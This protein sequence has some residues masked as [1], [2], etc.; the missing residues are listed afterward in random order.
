MTI[1]RVINGETVEIVLTSE[2]ISA[3][4]TEFVTNRM[5]KTVQ[6]I[7][8]DIPDE[9]AREIGEWA[10]EIYCRGDGQTEYES[11]EEAVEKYQQ[12]QSSGRIRKEDADAFLK[13]ELCVR[14]ESQEHLN[15]LIQLA[16]NEDKNLY[17]YDHPKYN[18]SYPFISYN[19]GRSCFNI[20]SISYPHD[21]CH[22]KYF[23]DTIN[24]DYLVEQLSVD[25]DEE[26]DIELD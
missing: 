9:V 8:A 16:K 25:M 5:T 12:E 10:Y 21:V 23:E 15:V 17:L 18:K 24:Q 4:N 2:E 26:E 11:V 7:D 22:T 14:I 20:K 6:E 3:A 13:G 1:I 19:P